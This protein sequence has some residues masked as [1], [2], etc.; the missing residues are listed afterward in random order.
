MADLTSL[1]APPT[2]VSLPETREETLSS[3]AQG[4]QG[5]GEGEGSGELGSGAV[6]GAGEERGSEGGEGE[7]AGGNSEEVV[8]GLRSLLEKYESRMQ[9]SSEGVM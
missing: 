3:P 2:T 4:P 6:P 7:G 9:V 5:Q 8:E 1:P